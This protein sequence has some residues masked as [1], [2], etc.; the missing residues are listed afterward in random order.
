ME[1]A[2]LAAV[3]LTSGKMERK[4]FTFFIAGVA[5]GILVTMLVLFWARPRFLQIPPELANAA[6]F[7]V[8]LSPDTLSDSILS[9]T[10]VVRRDQNAEA[11]GAINGLLQEAQLDPRVP[12]R[13]EGVNMPIWCELQSLDGTTTLRIHP[14]GVTRLD[15]DGTTTIYRCQYDL[16]YIMRGIAAEAVRTQRPPHVEPEDE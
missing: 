16:Y 11:V 9:G 1:V 8:T 13:F 7:R 12:K 3:G 14:L 5:A 10:A 6:A 4:R 2:R 15:R